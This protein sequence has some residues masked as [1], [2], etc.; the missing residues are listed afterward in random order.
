M[1][2]CLASRDAELHIGPADGPDVFEE[3]GEPGPDLESIELKTDLPIRRP[4]I[5][6]SLTVEQL[7]A[8]TRS[9]E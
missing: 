5:G 8:E 9:D 3:E 7:E 4:Q 2:L 1:K 6:E